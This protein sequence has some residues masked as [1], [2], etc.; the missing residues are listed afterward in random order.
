MSLL[1]KYNIDYIIDA[2]DS[3]NT[4]KKIIDYS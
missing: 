3:V 4:K 2:C 1:N